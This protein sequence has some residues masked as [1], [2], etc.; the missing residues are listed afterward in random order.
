MLPEQTFTNM[1]FSDYIGIIAAILTTVANVPQTYKI[2]RDKTTKGVSP[3]T[4]FVLLA[5]TLLWTAYGLF[6]G[7]WPLIAANGISSI[8]SSIILILYYISDSKIT[9]IHDNV[10]PEALQKNDSEAERS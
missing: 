2:I 9:K 4:Y 7:D 1:E 8:I 10:L 5:G 3:A 6:R